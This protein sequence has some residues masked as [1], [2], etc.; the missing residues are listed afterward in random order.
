MVSFTD[1]VCSHKSRD[2]AN[3]CEC[4]AGYTDLGDG[5]ACKHYGCQ[6][7]NYL[8]DEYPKLNGVIIYS[9]PVF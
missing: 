8:V 5:L 2:P 1:I 7:Y 3:N 6:E 4:K 9:T